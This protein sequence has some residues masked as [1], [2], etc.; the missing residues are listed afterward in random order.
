[1]YNKYILYDVEEG[2]ILCSFE[3]LNQVA[4]YVEELI[5]DEAIDP[6]CV[7]D[8]LKIF[9]LFPAT[10]RANVDISVSIEVS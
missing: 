4:K 8:E 6:N 7:N 10:I 3:D 9:K 2:Q 5:S 1:M